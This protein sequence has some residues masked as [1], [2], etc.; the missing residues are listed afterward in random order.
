MNKTPTLIAAALL[1]VTAGAAVAQ[2]AG[3]TG[4]S[5]PRKALDANNDGVVDRA[6]AAAHPRLAGKFDSLDAN[7]DGKLDRGEMPR[8]HG[9]GGRDGHPFADLDTD[10]DGRISKAEAAAKP[11]FAGRFAELDANSDGFVDKAD[12]ELA[13]R[14]RR[15]QWF[16]QADSNKDG[17]L[18]KAEYDAAHARRGAEGRRHG[19]GGRGQAPDA[20][21]K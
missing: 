11:E 14:Q 13:S 9:R 19:G 2:T 8:K 20:A 6:E 10:G 15:D 18:S 17:S 3:T 4:A 16:Q 5:P 12:R 21:R 7:K 1:A